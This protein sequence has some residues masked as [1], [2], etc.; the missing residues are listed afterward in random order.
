MC[1]VY[2]IHMKWQEVIKA[3]KN[4]KH[5]LCI[6]SLGL[7]TFGIST[8]AVAKG[9]MIADI[10]FTAILSISAAVYKPGLLDYCLEKLYL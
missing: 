5:P 10:I 3:K 2:K 6:Y 9:H 1:P 8:K 7:A 4:Y